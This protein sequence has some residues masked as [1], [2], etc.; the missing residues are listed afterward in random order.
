MLVIA[1]S[2]I[3]VLLVILSSSRVAA[4][5]IWWFLKTAYPEIR[6][7]PAVVVW[8]SVLGTVIPYGTQTFFAAA[9][10]SDPQLSWWYAAVIFFDTLAMTLVTF[11]MTLDGLLGSNGAYTAYT[12]PSPVIFA[13]LWVLVVF[14]AHSICNVTRVVYEVQGVESAKRWMLPAY[15]TQAWLIVPFLLG[16]EFFH[17]MLILTAMDYLQH[18]VALTY[19]CYGLCKLDLQPVDK[20]RYKACIVGVVFHM[21][22]I[23]PIL[24]LFSSSSGFLQEAVVLWMIVAMLVSQSAWIVAAKNTQ[25]TKIGYGRAS[26]SSDEITFSATASA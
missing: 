8:T 15:F 22:S 19:W 13:Q 3:A 17:L 14:P 12:A 4:H 1:P 25:T 18:T 7:L 20:R 24:A 9:S 26:D 21:V 5:N 10:L 23:L 2:V 11:R 16:V 6:R